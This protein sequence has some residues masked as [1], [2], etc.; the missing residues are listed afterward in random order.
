MLSVP[1]LGR[2]A[3][4]VSY[5]VTAVRSKRHRPPEATA[6]LQEFGTRIRVYELQGDLV[7]ASVEAFSR[8]I[9]AGFNSF[10]ILVIDLKHA[11]RIGHGGSAMMADLLRSLLDDGKRVALSRADPVPEF[12]AAAAAL[13]GIGEEIALFPDKDSALEWCEDRLLESVAPQLPEGWVPVAENELCEGLNAS[14]TA[15]LESVARQVRFSAGE[16]ILRS[17]D[18]GESV[19]LLVYGKVSV[20]ID[21]EGGGVARLAT[22]SA[23]MTFGEMAMLGDPVRSA[24]VIADSEAECHVLS[25]DDLAQLG[26]S[27]PPLRATLYQNLARKLATNLRRANAEVQALS[28]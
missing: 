24:D 9:A 6:A 15:R 11:G 16:T 20:V 10:D 25:V 3:V 12:V 13:A 7:F 22:L 27:D 18:P 4:R 8:Q 23:G 28:G 17:G 14:A 2:S 19:Y 1:N 26:E 5:D 21:R